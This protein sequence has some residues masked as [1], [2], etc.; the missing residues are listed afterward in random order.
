MLVGEEFEAASRHYPIGFVQVATQEYFPVAMVGLRPAENLFIMGRRWCEDAYIPAFVRR[1][2][3][4]LTAQGDVCIDDVAVNLGG[5]GDRLF[6]AD[7]AVAPMLQYTLSFLSAFQR[8]VRATRAFCAQL[9]RL[10]L[11][12]DWPA[13]VVATTG[14]A[15]QIEGLKVVDRVRLA[16]SSAIVAAEAWR[17]DGHGWI[18]AHHAS[19]DRLPELAARLDARPARLVA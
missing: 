19:L 9:E 6:E 17:T 15:Y 8:A 5:D 2:P 13:Q 12:T 7:G 4:V 1:H 14:E 16:A 3:F 11:L 18:E 10:G